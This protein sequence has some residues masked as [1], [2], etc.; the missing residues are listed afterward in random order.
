MAIRPAGQGRGGR[1]RAA[2]RYGV[3]RRSHV[4]LAIRL[5]DYPSRWTCRV[6]IRQQI[7]YV[8]ALSAPCNVVV[9]DGNRWCKYEASDDFVPDAC[10]NLA[11]LMQSIVKLFNRMR[12]S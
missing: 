11:R 5:F 1:C 9:T 6:G 2:I 3:T 7:G 8:S 12:R 4:A 10:A